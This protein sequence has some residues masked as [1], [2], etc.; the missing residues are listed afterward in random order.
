MIGDTSASSNISTQQQLCSLAHLAMASLTL[1]M[2]ALLGYVAAQSSYTVP[3]TPPTLNTSYAL[4]AAPVG[5]SFEFYAWPGW[6]ALDSTTQCLENL[7]NL[8]GTMPS[9]RIG[10]TTQ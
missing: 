10:G 1:S 7:G 5:V 6:E 3:S 2:L 9:I 4:S 8:S